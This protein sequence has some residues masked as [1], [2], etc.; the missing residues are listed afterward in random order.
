MRFPDTGVGPGSC[1]RM[2]LASNGNMV[3]QMKLQIR[4]SAAALSLLAVWAPFPGLV[5]A[6]A[7]SNSA[8]RLVEAV[9][10]QDVGL[11]RA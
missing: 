7:V 5:E 2:I 3:G 4:A 1:G 11:V 9:Q 8:K 6:Q 10:Q